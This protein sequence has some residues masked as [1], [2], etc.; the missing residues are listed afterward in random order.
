MK[1]FFTS[2]EIQKKDSGL[3]GET[4]EKV[5]Q[6]LPRRI[7]HRIQFLAE[8]TPGAY[9]VSYENRKITYGELAQLIKTTTQSLAAQG[10][11]PGDRVMIVCENSLVLV[12]LLM[13][14]SDMDAWAVIVNARLSDRELDHILTHCD[15][16]RVIFTIN[17]SQDAGKHARRHQA[18]PVEI[19]HVDTVAVSELRDTQP[20]P[21]EWA[22]KDQVFAMIYT[23]G[24]TGNPKGVMLTH[25]NIGYI[26]HV[27]GRLRETTAKDTVYAVLPM[28]HVFGL[29][30][31][32][33]SGF[34]AGACVYLES[35]FSVEKVLAVLAKGEITMLFGVPTMFVRMLEQINGKEE[36]PGFPNLRFVY[37]GGSPLDPM[38]K[39]RVEKT[40]ALSL[41]N[42]YGMT[43]TGPTLCQTRPYAPLENCSVGP[44]LPGIESALKSDY[45]DDAPKANEGE[46]WVRGPNVMKGYFREPELTGAVKND[47]GWINTGDVV[48]RDDQGNLTIIGRTKELIIRSGF[49]VFPPEVEAVINAHPGVSMSAVVGNIIEGDE[50]IVA[51]VKPMP[52]PGLTEEDLKQFL[53]DNLTAYKRPDKIFFL[54]DLPASPSGKILLSRLKEKAKNANS[55]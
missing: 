13:A 9:A 12:C 3:L 41:N 48:H 47:Q 30:S 53:K 28:S 21:V 2:R 5:I 52:N 45:S 37:A 1:P 11:R 49:N 39:R 23:T 27:T 54:E 18:E 33:I 26:A 15:P 44:I 38:V 4:P 7:S 34:F 29:S 22:G 43:E 24:T 31:V 25:E 55:H 42:G 8:N 32:V 50:E 19:F 40:F 6:K 16:R 35:R 14:L 36:K 46:L 17:V 10:V 51:F 20:E